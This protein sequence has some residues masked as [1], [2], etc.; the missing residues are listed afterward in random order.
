MG[1]E[2]HGTEVA[3]K[4]TNPASSGSITGIQKNCSRKK[5]IDLANVDQLS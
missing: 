2:W 1:L 4:L 5:N 3:F